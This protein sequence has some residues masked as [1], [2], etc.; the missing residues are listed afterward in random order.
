[1]SVATFPCP[2]DCSKINH[3]ASLSIQMFFRCPTL[4]H[5]H[6]ALCER[7]IGFLLVL[8]SN[9]KRFWYFCNYISVWLTSWAT[10]SYQNPSI[11][12]YCLHA[13]GW[14]ERIWKRITMQTDY[15]ESLSNTKPPECLDGTLRALIKQVFF[16]EKSSDRCFHIFHFTYYKHRGKLLL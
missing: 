13:V 9:W 8:Y 1:M 14:N 4:P 15:N 16:I 3:L 11:C 2:C 6:R 5:N 12:L 7:L 10:H